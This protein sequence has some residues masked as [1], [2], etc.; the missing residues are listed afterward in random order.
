MNVLAAT[1][2]TKNAAISSIV[3]MNR[4]I[5][6]RGAQP[7]PGLSP[8]AA[9]VESEVAKV[10]PLRDDGDEV[11]AVS[12]PFRAGGQYAALYCSSA[13]RKS[14]STASGSP[15]ALRTLSAQAL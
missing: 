4:S 14:F 7:G 2:P 1:R 5:A 11:A 10:L 15:P 13:A 8:I 6:L 9:A 12:S 3:S